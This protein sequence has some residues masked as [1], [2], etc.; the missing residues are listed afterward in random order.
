VVPFVAILARTASNVWKVCK[1]TWRTGNPRHYSIPLALV[2]L[3]GLIHAG[4]EDWLFAV[5]AY[6]CVFF[7]VFAFLLADLTPG[8]V[9]APLANVVPRPRRPARAGF[10]TIVPYP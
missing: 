9:E 2:V 1:W 7:W 10:G 4:F 3:S 8:A 5:G 6:P